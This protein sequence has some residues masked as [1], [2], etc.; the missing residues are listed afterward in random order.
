MSDKNVEHNSSEEKTP[1]VAD[2]NL[3]YLVASTDEPLLEVTIPE[4]LKTTTSKFPNQEAAVFIEQNIRWTWQEFSEQVDKLALGFMALGLTKGDRVGIWSPNR[5]EWLLT[6]FATARL[7]IIL[8]T[9][10]PAYK[11]HELEYVIKNAGCR[12]LVIAESFKSSNYVE[13]VQELIPDLASAP[14]SAGPGKYSGFPDLEYIIKTGSAPVAGMLL[15]NG[16]L[17]RSETP[18]ALAELD[19]ISTQL[20]PYEPI[21]IQ[22]TSGTTGSPKGAT[23]SHHN[24]V[25]NGYLV[26]KT[27]N[28]SEKDRLLIPVPLYHCFGMVMGVLGCASFGAAMIFPAEAFEP[29]SVLKAIETERCTALYGVPTMF[30]AELESPEFKTYDLSSM[31]TGIMAGAPCP[32]EI[33]KRVVTEMNMP[34]VT[35]AYGMTETSPVSFQSAVNDSLE[36]RVS[37]VGR[38]HPHLEVKLI[39]SNGEITP[40]GTQGELCTKGYSVMLGYWND[41]ERTKASID[42][43]GFMHTGDLATFDEEG[44]CNIVGRVKDMVIRG[45]ENIYP[46]EIEEFL[47]QHP[48]IQQV[49]VFGVPDEKFGEE[50]CAWIVLQEG[51]ES[52]E[53]EIIDYC[54]GQ[55][56]HYKIPR[57]V[58]FRKELPLTVTGKPQKFIMRDQMTKELGLKAL[59]TA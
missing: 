7:G 23:L 55:I 28:F 14:P 43:D 2:S 8:V 59:Q 33:M 41:D 16:L 45:G 13:M 44:F 39:D 31:R 35:I 9:V 56:A 36:K 18:D 19:K 38:I 1:S 42:S 11:L 54:K 27:I 29:N 15:F 10:N 47:F 20:N 37:T 30:V 49:Q 50:L 52:T 21:N 40:I 51:E 32:I 26:T 48:K 12:A 57:Y 3:S 24:I 34:E 25:N 4:L 58:S 22:F 5:S 46:R 6:Q 53:E 17:E